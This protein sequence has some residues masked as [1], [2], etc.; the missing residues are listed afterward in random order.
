MSRTSRTIAV[1]CFSAGTLAYEILLV[2]V[3]AIEHF[4]HFAYMAIGV[5]MLGFGVSGTALAL[6]RPR[7]APTRTRWFFRAGVATAIALVASPALVHQISLDPTQLVWDLDQ[8]LRLGVVYLLL[9]L[10][11]AAGALS[12]LLALSIDTE[13]PGWVYG[14][15]FVGSGLGAGLAIAVLWLVL[16]TRALAIPALVAGLGCLAAAWGAER[17]KQSLWSGGIV[18]LVTAM[19]VI[20]PPWRFTLSPFKALPQVEAYP[21]ARR[22]AE[23]SSPIGWVIAATA[24]AFRYAP[25]LSL[26]FTGEL[27]PQTGLFVD[28][29]LTGAVT[30]W[31]DRDGAMAV[32][33]WLPTALPY[34]LGRRDHVLVVGGGSGIE[35]ANAVAHGAQQITALELNPD[36][37]ELNRELGELPGDGKRDVHWVLGDARSYVARTRDTFDLI[38]LG[39]GG[40]FGSAT[41]GVL[42]LGED[43]LNTREAYHAYLKRLTNR[44]VLSITGWLALPPRA[45]VRVLLTVVDALRDLV[46]DRVPLAF[47]VARSWG[48]VTV[49]AKPSGFIPAEIDALREW[50]A[51]RSFD[52]DWYPGIAEPTDGWNQLSEPVFFEAAQAAATGRGSAERFAESYPFDVS[53]ATDLRPY[54][55]HFLRVRALGV[56]LKSDRGSWLP[57]AE[58]GTLALV[59]TLIQ[60]V[61]L[62]G[63]LLILP[64]A[65]RPR[66]VGEAGLAPVIVYF[67]AI[68]LAYLAAEIAAI[69]QLGL[70]LGHPVYAV[71]AVLAAF[72][73]FSGGGSVWSDRLGPARRVWVLGAIVPAL[74][75]WVLFLPLLVHL[76]QPAPLVAR[77]AAALV[78]LGP[79][80]F[81]MGMPF[82][83]GIRTL[84]RDNQRRLAWAWAANGFASVTAAPLAALVALEFGSTAVLIAAATAYAVAGGLLWTHPR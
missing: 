21:D 33:G 47:V 46:P 54:P 8:W 66:K 52:L 83:L 79:V 3:F 15:S 49:L 56:L 71:A 4:H 29:E 72:L 26:G 76:V 77:G 34:A 57:F 9:A 36:I 40:A 65:V 31:G 84:A 82:P 16:P 20:H 41:G 32:L 24:P 73:L 42:A 35:V 58:W 62:A 10:P 61:V 5:A 22:V 43:F 12:I 74:L 51:S 67:A 55:H 7:D 27:P 68:G 80:A 11:F 44:G 2:R 53:P 6:A 28:G 69:Q 19:A 23:R 14:A 18:C 17:R 70:L 60:S 38:T 59:A 37:A 78:L 39:P 81:L 64:V 45:N 50:A 1:I 75:C 63:V 30:R 13:R 48:T 25:G